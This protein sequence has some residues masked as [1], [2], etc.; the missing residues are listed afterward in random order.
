[1]LQACFGAGRDERV[2][3]AIDGLLEQQPRPLLQHMTLPL[4]E[5]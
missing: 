5:R 3:G 2:G 4:H 1:M